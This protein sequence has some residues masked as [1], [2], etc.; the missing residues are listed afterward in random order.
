M[1]AARCLAMLVPLAALSAGCPES[2]PLFDAP[3]QMLGPI[4]VGGRV[5]WIDQPRGLVHLVSP[6]LEGDVR[7]DVVPIGHDPQV[8][9]TDTDGDRL[10]VVTHGTPGGP[11]VAAEE[12]ALWVIDARTATTERWDVRSPFTAIGVHPDGR[13]LFLHFDQSVHQRSELVY[14]AHEIAVI[15]L[16]EPPGPDNPRL[17]TVRSF[18]Q[19]PSRVVFA[20]PV[21]I[22]GEEIHFAAVLGADYV[23]LFDLDHA[24]RTELSIPLT[25][26]PTL[27][28][29]DPKEVVFHQPDPTVDPVLYVAASGAEDVFAFTLRG[30]EEVTQGGHHF[31][32][33]PNLYAVGAIPSDLE[34]VALESGDA[35]LVTTGSTQLWIIDTRS[36]Q[37]VTVHLEAA[38]SEVLPVP[39][40]EGVPPELL[41]WDPGSW[42][43]QFAL[44]E[45][46]E[47]SVERQI[48]AIGLPGPVADVQLLPDG[49]SAAV[50]HS[51]DE[52]SVS[53]LRLDERSASA[54]TATAPLDRSVWSADGATLFVA[55]GYDARLSVIDVADRHPEDLRLDE[56]PKGLLLV[57]GTRVLVVTHEAAEGLVTLI[58][59]ANPSRETARMLQGFLL[60]GLLDQR[61]E[62]R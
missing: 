17:D 1:N 61:G 52:R 22:S 41:L 43:V 55:S 21:Q 35:L 27:D 10:L 46:L 14:N 2:A 34:P 8:A 16:E 15:D 23:T 42:V 48:D 54:L 56:D 18:E 26:D 62:R 25:L 33:A 39:P 11:G 58:D 53:I 24:D 4:A 49:V 40:A 60:E 44:V 59:A 31:V 7:H 36:S 37:A 45:G 29:V 3:Y 6:A 50:I 51:D 30:V 20:P 28:L 38:A 12:Q 5:A 9:T 19:V 57:P 47:D 32:V 13:R